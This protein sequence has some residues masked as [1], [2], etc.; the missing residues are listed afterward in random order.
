MYEI[1]SISCVLLFII[2]ALTSLLFEKELEAAFAHYNL[3]GGITHCLGFAVQSKLCFYQKTYISITSLALFC[4]TYLCLE[5]KMRKSGK[6][7]APQQRNVETL[8]AAVVGS[9]LTVSNM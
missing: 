3:W 6:P 1:V 2:S 9:L 8:D 5:I 4:L 7:S